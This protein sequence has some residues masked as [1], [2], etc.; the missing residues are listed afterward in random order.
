MDSAGDDALEKMLLRSDELQ[1]ALFQRLQ[2]AEFDGSV[3]AEAV[4][5]MCAVTFEHATGM[6]L[7]IA[8]GCFTPALALMR[9]QY[10]SLTRAMWLLYVAGDS[11]VE[12]M[13]AP[14]TLESEQAAKSL[15]SVNEMLDHIRKGVGT[16]VPARAS[17]MLDSFREM[18]WRSLNSYV[19][20]GIHAIRRQSDGYPVKLILDVIRSSNALSTMAEMTLALLTD[21]ET[22]RSMGRIQPE[23][24]DCLPELLAPST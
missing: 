10:E 21:E 23:F 22:A 6:R 20:G 24:A 18:Q 13:S 15:P 7:L 8:G 17:E 2:E 12:K 9:L 14:L 3:R 5:G 1:A 16:R 4:V 19:H 11:A